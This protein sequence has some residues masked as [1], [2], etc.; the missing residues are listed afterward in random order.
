MEEG[1]CC[2]LLLFVRDSCHHDRRIGGIEGRLFR[3][4]RGG[5][6]TCFCGDLF[7][8]SGVVAGDRLAD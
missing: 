8:R 5:S 1:G 2:S 7:C 4:Q 6:F 3:A